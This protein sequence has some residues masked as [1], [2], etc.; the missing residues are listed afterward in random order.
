M[1]IKKYLSLI[2]AGVIVAAILGSVYLSLTWK[3]T[4]AKPVIY[5]GPEIRLPE[6]MYSSDISVEEALIMRRSIRA[7]SQESLTL[8]DI[9]QLLWAAQGIT[10]QRFLRT[11]PSAG[12]TYPL[13]VYLVAG[14][15][16]G[17]APGVYHYRPDGHLLTRIRGG[18]YRMELQEAALDQ[19]WIGDAAVDL[20][21]TA[22]YDRTT[23]RY[24]ERGT[25]YVHLEAGHAAQNIYLQATALGL[26]TVSVGAFD[27]DRVIEVLNATKEETPLYIMPI[28]RP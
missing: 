10:G 23:D 25:R 2:Y 13:E 22:V 4:I 11:A 21:I 18:D 3:P 20:V 19:R 27:D 1:H 15:V 7:Y 5:K 6:P 12:G 26:G 17:L 8:Q 24:G 16:E 9:S 14:N 28:G